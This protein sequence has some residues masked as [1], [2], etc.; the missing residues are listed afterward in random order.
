MTNRTFLSDETCV[1][2]AHGRKKGHFYLS[3]LLMSPRTVLRRRRLVRPSWSHVS[4]PLPGASRRPVHHRPVPPR[5]PPRRRAAAPPPPRARLA[6]RRPDRPLREH[7]P[8]GRPRRPSPRRGLPSR[9]Q[10]GQRHRCGPPRPRRYHHQGPRPRA[11]RSAPRREAHRVHRDR[12]GSDQAVAWRGRRLERDGR[13]KHGPAPR[14][15]ATKGLSPR[16]PDRRR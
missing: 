2:G 3:P 5:R 11:T 16:G 10:R 14:Y 12:G 15:V 4:R 1:F 8:H 6:P 7:L 9:R 13:G